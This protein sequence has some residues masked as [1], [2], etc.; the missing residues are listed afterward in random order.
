MK[1][2][3]KSMLEERPAGPDANTYLPEMIR[4]YG[5]LVRHICRNAL[6]DRPED[7]DECVSDVFVALWEKVRSGGYDPDVQGVKQYLCGIARNKAIS[8]YRKVAARPQALP[9][10][11]VDEGAAAHGVLAEPDVAELLARGDDEAMLAEAV[12]SLPP[13][14]RDVFILRYC[15][16]ERVKAIAAKLGTTEKSVENILY[17]GKL[18][19]RQKLAGSSLSKE[20]HPGANYMKKNCEVIIYG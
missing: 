18:S 1:E 5:G 17:R 12:A 11:G 20:G 16:L 14:E 2:M 9:L 15:Y 13:R 6:G 19:L 3:V 8:R 10:D 4:L 7:I